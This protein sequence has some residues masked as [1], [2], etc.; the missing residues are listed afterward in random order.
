MNFSSDPVNYKLFLLSV[1]NQYSRCDTQGFTYFTSIINIAPSTAT[2]IL[3][4][5]VYY[6]SY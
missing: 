5:G 1:T 3:F 2:I 6:L 4:L